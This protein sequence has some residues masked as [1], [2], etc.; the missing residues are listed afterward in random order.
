MKTWIKREFGGRKRED[1]EMSGR[2]IKGE[3]AEELAAC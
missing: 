3:K 2:E 1:E